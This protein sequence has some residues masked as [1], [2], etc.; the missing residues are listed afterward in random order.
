MLNT[1]FCLPIESVVDDLTQFMSTS[2]LIETVVRMEIGDLIR[3][4]RKAQNLTQKD[5]AKK[6]KVSQS[7]VSRWESG[8]CNFTIHTLAQIAEALKLTL[9]NPIGPQDQFQCT[10]LDINQS[11]QCPAFK[12]PKLDLQNS[13]LEV[14]A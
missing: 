4:T 8:D 6:M 11:K 2:D 12:I 9:T 5:F 7:I 10:S 13:L 3:N 14:A 1:E